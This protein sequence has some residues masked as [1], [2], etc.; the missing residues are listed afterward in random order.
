MSLE[1]QQGVGIVAW[2]GTRLRNGRPGRLGVEGCRSS[3]NASSSS[4]LVRPTW[5]GPVE[6]SY[7]KA[8]HQQVVGEPPLASDC[9]RQGTGH[10]LDLVPDEED[11]SFRVA[12]VAVVDWEEER[13]R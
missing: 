7:Y 5:A 2:G 6:E 1:V 13:C 8:V 4:P 10:E 9:E 11:P 3:V 12:V